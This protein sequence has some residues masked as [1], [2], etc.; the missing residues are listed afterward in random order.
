MMGRIGQDQGQLFYSFNLEEVV[1]DDHLVRA[2]AGVVD[3]SW[4]RAE[5]APHYSPIDQ[6]R[7]DRRAATHKLSALSRCHA[8]RVRRQPVAA[9]RL[10]CWAQPRRTPA[11]GGGAATRR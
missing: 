2:I 5:L 11:I 4:V 7:I 1:P 6:H 9:H 3:L 8:G 10:V